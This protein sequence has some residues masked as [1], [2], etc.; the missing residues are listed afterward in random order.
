MFQ[1][2]KYPS[3]T[4][5][6]AIGCVLSAASSFP[7]VAQ[8]VTKSGDSLENIS[9]DENLDWSFTSEREPMSVKD[10]LPPNSAYSISEEDGTDV[11][12][13]GSEPRWGNRGDVED[14]SIDFEVYDY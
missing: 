6:I 1:L 14:Y 11:E 10:D 2:R 7:L 8:T 5:A 12:L 4:V 3:C 9:T 13:E